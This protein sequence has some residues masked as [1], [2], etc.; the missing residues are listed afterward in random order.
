LLCHISHHLRGSGTLLTHQSV[1][2]GNQKTVSWFSC[3]I[4]AL[5]ARLPGKSD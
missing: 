3:T 2:F 5:T 1:T 4:G